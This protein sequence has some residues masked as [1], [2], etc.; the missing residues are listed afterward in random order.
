LNG[1]YEKRDEENRWIMDQKILE[2]NRRMSDEPGD[3]ISTSSV[4]ER[5]I[6]RY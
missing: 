3:K 6:D 1:L 2:T 4:K 5:D